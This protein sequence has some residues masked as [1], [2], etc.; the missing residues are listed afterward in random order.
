MPPATP[1]DNSPRT[2]LSLIDT[3]RLI[4]WSTAAAVVCVATVAAIVSYRHAFHVVRSYGEDGLTARVVP[5]TV[6]GLIYASSMVMLH[7]AR[8]RTP[9]PALARWLLGL[10]IA[11]TVAANA[12]H[13]LADGLVG[14]LV[15][16]WPA[17]ALVGSYELLMLMVRNM[18]RA[19]EGVS[20]PTQDVVREP[21]RI[22]LVPE[23]P[24]AASSNVG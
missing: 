3:D 22:S 24:S 20:E 15:A 11:A 5:L 10:G 16:A 6:D 8:R 17:F 13:G 9:V 2:F 18:G 19:S 14:A 12:A 4:R 7:S 1:H 23:M 21:A